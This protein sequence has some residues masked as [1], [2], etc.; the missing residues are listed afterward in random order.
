MYKFMKHEEDRKESYKEMCERHDQ[1][2][3]SDE[4]SKALD[5]FIALCLLAFFLTITLI[6]KTL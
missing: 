1:E 5:G 6:I 3:L 2:L 4:E